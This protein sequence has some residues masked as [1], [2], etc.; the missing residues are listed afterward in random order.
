M[1]KKRQF[2]MVIIAVKKRQFFTVI[3]VVKKEVVLGG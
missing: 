3:R 1:V 2:R